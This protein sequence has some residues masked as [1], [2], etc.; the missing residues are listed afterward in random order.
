MTSGGSSGSRRVRAQ[1]RPHPP[2]ALL[3]AL[4]VV[5]VMGNT[6]ITAAI[7]DIRD[8]LGV[9]SGAAG[10]LIAATAAPGIVMAPL[11]GVLADRYGRREVLL[12]CL[13]MFGLSGGL[14]AF[15]DSFG[16][17]LALRFG[18]GMG[19]AGLLNLAVVLIGDHW[20]GIERTRLIGRNAA[21]LIGSIVVLPPLGGL[22]ADTW[23]WQATF[24]P[25]WIALPMAG[26]VIM[27]VP[28]SAGGTRTIREQLRETA[29][30]ARSR[31]VLGPVSLAAA[32]FMLIF[33]LFLTVMPVM[34]KDRFDVGPGGRGLI[35]SLAAVTSSA[36]ALALGRLTARFGLAPVMRFAA[37]LWI[38][39][40]VLIATAPGLVVL[41]TGVLVYGF[42][43]GLIIPTI[44]D[45]VAGAA[46]AS[47]RGAVVA[48][49]VAFARAGQTA[50]PLLGGLALASIGGRG[51]FAVGAGVAVVLVLV[52]RTL[53]GQEPTPPATKEGIPA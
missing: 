21:V 45:A 15:A 27:F 53:M 38:P 26:A 4:S 47:S 44:Q 13:V 31:A 11:I 46:P 22:L 28:R 52:Q 39:A 1:A 18:Q 29:P 10:L 20:D 34:L 32:A 35:L 40:F 37:L 7:P 24:V 17:L 49:F 14:A 33:G 50:G 9:G 3:A 12:P 42:G 30:Y 43:E 51:A 8:D 19:S 36:G 48:L 25:F 6:L 23:G 16:V 41:G 5:S 2:F